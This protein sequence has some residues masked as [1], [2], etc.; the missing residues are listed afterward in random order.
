MPEKY[1]GLAKVLEEKLKVE[2]PILSADQVEQINQTL[3]VTIH[4]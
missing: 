2:Q 1:V 4:K 3:P